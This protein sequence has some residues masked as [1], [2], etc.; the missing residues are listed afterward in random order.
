MIIDIFLIVLLFFLFAFIHSFLAS[1]EFKKR[2]AVNI[3][4][5][6]AFYRLF[7]NLSS[8]IFF[9]AFLF[10]APKPDVIIYDLHYPFDIITFVLQIISLVALLWSIKGMDLKEFLG[11]AQLM[12]Y[13]KGEYKIDDVDAI[14]NFRVEGAY[15]F[16]RHPVY[17]FSILFLGLR[18]T[19]DLFYFVTFICIIIYFYIGSYFEEKKLI[20]K[21]GINYLEYQKKVPRLIPYKIFI[22]KWSYR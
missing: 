12:R 14:D 3:G 10:L 2:L 16:V 15:K 1:N 17:F 20:E 18:P 9:L 21:Y 5:K 22:S 7:Y 8:I 11:I 19:M 4:E 6:I 13:I